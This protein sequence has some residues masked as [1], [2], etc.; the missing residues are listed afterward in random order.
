M[1]HTDRLFF[2]ADHGTDHT[3]RALFTVVLPNSDN[4]MTP[5]SRRCGPA[6][7]AVSSRV[8]GRW[9]PWLRLHSRG[10]LL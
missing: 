2:T 6:L 7:M 5:K 10:S 1:N 8:T 9:S 3:G 4:M